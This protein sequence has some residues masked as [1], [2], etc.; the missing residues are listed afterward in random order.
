MLTNFNQLPKVIIINCS[1][2]KYISN[3]SFKIHFKISLSK[4]VFQ[5]CF[6]KIATSKN[7]FQNRSFKLL[8]QKMHLKT[9]LTKIFFISASINA[10]KDKISINKSLIMHD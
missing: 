3:F 9:A 2:K 1:L 8:P 10:V 5:N 7:A 4:N 6:F